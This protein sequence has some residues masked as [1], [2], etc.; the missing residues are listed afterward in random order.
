MLMSANSNGKHN[1]V[2]EQSG[3]ITVSKLLS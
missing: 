3:W 2:S 1:T